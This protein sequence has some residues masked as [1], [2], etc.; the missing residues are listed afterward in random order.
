MQLPHL[1]HT[2]SHIHIHTHK[3][4]HTHS[5]RDYSDA[6]FDR[7]KGRIRN[8]DQAQVDF[9]YADQPCVFAK[10][11]RRDA[12]SRKP[13]GGI[14]THKRQFSRPHQSCHKQKSTAPTQTPGCTSRHT[15]PHTRCRITSIMSRRDHVGNAFI[16]WPWPFYFSRVVGCCCFVVARRRLFRPS[17]AA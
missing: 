13:V 12:Y 2:H 7:K 4:T 10:T 17:P 9:R 5:H 11:N 3:Q 16:W 15:S 8:W 6:G 1:L 14:F